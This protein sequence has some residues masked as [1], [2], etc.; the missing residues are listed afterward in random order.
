[1][2]AYTAQKG[3]RMERSLF[4]SSLCG[5]HPLRHHPLFFLSFSSAM[6]RVFHMRALLNSQAP[7]GVPQ[8][9]LSRHALRHARI[10]IRAASDAG[11]AFIAK[12]Y[13]A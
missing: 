6:A 10:D 4:V 1:M 8:L 5:L 13:T 2:C 7:H 3:A 9:A 11:Q 12:K